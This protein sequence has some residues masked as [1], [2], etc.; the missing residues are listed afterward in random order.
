MLLVGRDEH[1]VAGR[2]RD[3][4]A[5]GRRHALPRQHVD[6]FLEP[7]V[8]VRTALGG[9][10]CGWW[11]LGDAEGHAR[12]DV[13]GDRLERHAPRKAEPLRFLLLQQPRHQRTCRRCRTSAGPPCTASSSPKMAEVSPAIFSAMSSSMR[14]PFSA[15]ACCGLPNQPAGAIERMSVSTG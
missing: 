9:A 13:A 4:A 8:Q 12:A 5:L 15:V 14:I 6:A 1:N 3:L 7:V 11:N 10:R 2:D